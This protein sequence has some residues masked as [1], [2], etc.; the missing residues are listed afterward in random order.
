MRYEGIQ[1]DEKPAVNNVLSKV[2]FVLF[3]VIVF[4][5]NYMIVSFLFR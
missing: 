1:R 5:A 4:C 3:L 2:N